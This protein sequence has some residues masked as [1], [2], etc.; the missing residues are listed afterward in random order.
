MIATHGKYAAMLLLGFAAAGCNDSNEPNP[1]PENNAPTANFTFDCTDLACTFTN[2]SSDSDG[3]VT[4]SSWDFGDAG[5][6]NNSNPSHT[7]ASAADFQ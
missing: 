3:T 7:Y 1:N 5:S 6:S 2:L 4:A